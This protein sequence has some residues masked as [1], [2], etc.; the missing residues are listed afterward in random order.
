MIFNHKYCRMDFL[1]ESLLR[2]HSKLACILGYGTGQVNQCIKFL[3]WITN[4]Q[5]AI[6]KLCIAASS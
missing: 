5:N 1:I 3:R 2:S 4:A 6:I